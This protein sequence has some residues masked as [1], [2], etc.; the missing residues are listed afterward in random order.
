M[1]VCE[2]VTQLMNKFL[3]CLCVSAYICAYVSGCEWLYVRVRVSQCAYD[4]M[5]HNLVICLY[6]MFA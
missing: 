1:Y 4:S 2:Y 6:W 3:L 5:F